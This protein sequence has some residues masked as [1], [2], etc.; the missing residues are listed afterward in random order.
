[1]KHLRIVLFIFASFITLGLNAQ[2]VDEII[3]KHIEA[4]GG[5][6]KLESLKTVKMEANLS[7][8]GMDI[9]VVITRVHNTGQRVDITAMGMSGYVITTPTAGWQFMP[10]MG[11]TA[12]EALPEDAVKESADEFDLHGSLLNYKEKGNTV[13][14]VGKEAVD[15]TECFKVK[16]TTKLGKTRTLFIDPKNYYLIRLVQKANVMGQ[17]QEVTVNYGDFKKTEDGYVFAHSIGGAF[18]Q[19]DM[20]VTKIEVNKPV[21]EKLFKP[22][23]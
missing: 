17:E 4:L 5:K 15:G 14:L 8:Q 7:V 11:Q 3:G 9:P 2:T 21:D 19:G 16:L 10:F 12:A 6:E 22:S 18:G 23:N 13:E 20:V 1:M